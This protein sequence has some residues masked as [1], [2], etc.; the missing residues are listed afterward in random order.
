MRAQTLIIRPK[1][2]LGPYHE[3]ISWKRPKI[4]EWLERGY[5]DAKRTLSGSSFAIDSLLAKTQTLSA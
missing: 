5:E 1:R 3:A 4:K 2:P